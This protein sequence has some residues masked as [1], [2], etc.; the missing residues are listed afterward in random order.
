MKAIVLKKPGKEPDISL[1][2]VETPRPSAGH[3]LVRLRWAALNRL[4]IWVKGGLPGGRYPLIMGAD[5]AGIVEEPGEGVR[6][7]AAGEEVLLDP[8]ISCGS[9]EYCAAGEESL[10]TRIEL[11][12]EGTNGTFAQYISVPR[13]NVHRVPK[14]FSLR[15]AAAFPL[16]FVTAWRMLF[17]KA[18]LRKG[19]WVLIHG[20]GGGV[21]TA[22]LVLC[23]MAGARIIVT[24][25]SDEKLERARERGAAY[26]INYEK[27]DVEA[28]VRRITAKRG[29][30]V[31]VDSVGKST[32]P[33]SIRSLARGGRLV[34]C[35]ATSGPDPTADVVR[36]FWNQL[37]ILGSTMGS[38]REFRDMVDAVEK[39]QL[40]PII[41][42]GFRMED[43]NRALAR[44]EEGRQFGK[45][46]L[47]IP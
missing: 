7:I 18:C 14:G 23:G 22:C 43:L 8:T 41:D 28:E 21:S 36:I 4:D 27:A 3:V 30:D 32:F 44:L 42:S 11:L 6:D 10:C 31:V 38:R 16:T 17:T 12:G 5:G 40:R 15:E 20:V 24:S 25:K 29:V 34:T 45:I 35:G 39:M 19:E 26:G 9:C 37:S 47:E 33:A 1:E 46:V 13:P 2:E